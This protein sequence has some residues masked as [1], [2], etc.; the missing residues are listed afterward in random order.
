MKPNKYIIFIARKF[1]FWFWMKLMNGFAPSDKYGNYKRPNGFEIKNKFDFQLDNDKNYYL[2]LGHS[3]PWCHRLLIAYKLFNLS[4]NIRIIFLNPNYDSGEW[5]FREEFYKNKYLKDLYRKCNQTK[6]FRYTLPL[7]VY[8]KDQ[9]FKLISNESREILKILSLLQHNYQNGK[10]STKYCDD[11]ILNLINDDINDGVYKCGFARNQSAYIA[12]SNKLFNGLNKIENLLIENGGPWILG[13]DLSF[14]D[15]YLFPTIIRWELIYSKL[16]KCTE[17]DI[18]EFKNIIYWRYKF[19]YHKEIMDTCHEEKWL[20]D[21]Y[22]AIFPLNP[23]Q[24]IPLQPSLKE[25]MDLQNL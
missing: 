22:Q 15:I 8:C 19:F 18:K 21:Y 1:W 9:N 23:N 16:F 5:I 3:C 11:H 10:N 12:A 25:I 6:T 17:K 13:K 4:K 20:K 7:F 2:L 14:A 24:I